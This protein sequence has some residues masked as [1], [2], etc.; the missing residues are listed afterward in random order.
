M[1]EI[2][3]NEHQRIRNEKLNQQRV[4]IGIIDRKLAL[5]G[6]KSCGGWDPRDHDVFLR[7]WAQS[8]I[9][10]IPN[11]SNKSQGLD[12][13]TSSST[14]STIPPPSFH[15][16]STNNS[17]VEPSPTSQSSSIYSHTS[18]LPIKQL[19]GLKKR[20]LPLLPGI[21]VEVI[22]DHIEW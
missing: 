9:N 15:S 7:A 10:F 12:Q 16:E 3:I 11:C 19:N 2:E 18:Q 17:Q 20:L 14:S 13:P 4:E 6:S 8:G 22:T 1:K 5:L 21:N